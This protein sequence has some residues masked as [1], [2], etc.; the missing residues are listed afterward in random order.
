MPSHKRLVVEVKSNAER[1]LE[2][3]ERL[4]VSVSSLPAP[5]VPTSASSL[6]VPVASTNENR[7]RSAEISDTEPTRVM[8]QQFNIPA[9]SL[10]APFVSANENRTQL[11]EIPG[12]SFSSTPK[13]QAAASTSYVE[14]NIRSDWPKAQS[15]QPTASSQF[16]ENSQR[17]DWPKAQSSQP[18]ASSQFGENFQRCDWP[19]AQ[20]SQPTASSQCGANFQRDD[21]HSNQ[22]IT[23]SQNGEKFQRS[24]WSNS[25]SDQPVASS[26][27]GGKFQRSDWP[28]LHS[29]QPITY[30]Q[31]GANFQRSD[32]PKA[33]SNKP[34]ASSQCGA[35]SQRGDWPNFQL[36]GPIASLQHG[37][38]NVPSQVPESWRNCQEPRLAEDSPRYSYAE[39]LKTNNSTAVKSKILE[40]ATNVSP[41]KLH[42]A[43][44]C[45]PTKQTRVKMN[46][47]NASTQDDSADSDTSWLA[48]P[49][50]WRNRHRPS[51]TTN[52]PSEATYANQKAVAKP[53]PEKNTALPNDGVPHDIKP[54]ITSTPKK[55]ISILKRD[56]NALKNKPYAGNLQPEEIDVKDVAFIEED[57]DKSVIDEFRSYASVEKIDI[58][59]VAF[60]EEDEYKSAIDESQLYASVEEVDDK[61]AGEKELPETIQGKILRYRPKNSTS[62]KNTNIVDVQ[63]AENNQSTPSTSKAPSSVETNENTSDVDDYVSVSMTKRKRGRPP[64]EKNDEPDS[65][66]WPFH[67]IQMNITS[68]LD[69]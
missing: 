45:A 51:I 13:K 15:S 43:T 12:P 11:V 19:K 23:Y 34:V 41:K 24:D 29:N 37:E 42:K 49:E 62:V 16:G 69:T 6:P 54:P 7:T 31:F 3:M 28:N 59:N 30:S 35:N 38:N 1:A 14:L 65:E 55:K 57:E 18:T 68:I 47:S 26:K 64:E 66:P 40:T 58:K 63:F 2:M 67:Q 56:T 48:L 50:G 52:D 8:M 61:M 21:W 32:W 20:S 46:N 9:S 4:N 33:Q 22:P 44:A 17:C 25:H 5:I 27:N 39:A 53:I 10:P 36:N 60:I